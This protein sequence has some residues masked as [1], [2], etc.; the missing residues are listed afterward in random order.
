MYDL[1]PK[2]EIGMGR[3]GLVVPIIFPVVASNYCKERERMTA[4]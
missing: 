2:E 4:K 1:I 3:L